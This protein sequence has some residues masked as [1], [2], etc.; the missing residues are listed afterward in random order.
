MP[1]CFDGEH[2]FG[3]PYK[4]EC[5]LARHLIATT[6]KRFGHPVRLRERACDC[7]QPLG[8]ETSPGL[9]PRAY[10]ADLSGCRLVNARRAVATITSAVT[11]SA[12]GGIGTSVV[13]WLEESCRLKVPVL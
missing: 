12:G 3:A 4:R 7:R 6:P 5:P 8:R 13:V 11:A 10:Q 9:S 1:S 2:W